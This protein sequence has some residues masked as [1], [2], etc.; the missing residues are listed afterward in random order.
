MRSTLFFAVLGLL[1]ADAVAGVTFVQ[2]HEPR[3]VIVGKSRVH[4]KHNAHHD[5]VVYF[6]A[7]IDVRGLEMTGWDYDYGLG[8]EIRRR[9]TVRLTP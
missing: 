6:G 8:K 5:A 7:E 9:R 1:T 4:V 2:D 3:A